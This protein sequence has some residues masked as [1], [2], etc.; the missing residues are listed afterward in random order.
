MRRFRATATHS[1]PIHKCP[2]AE[3]I[4]CICMPPGVGSS[5]AVGTG[6][7]S[8]LVRNQRLKITPPQPTLPNAMPSTPARQRSAPVPQHRALS[9]HDV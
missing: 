3:S 4:A 8:A 6:V 1:C 7:G 5:Q 9:S 2:Y